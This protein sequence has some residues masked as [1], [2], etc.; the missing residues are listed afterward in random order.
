MGKHGWHQTNC[1]CKPWHNLCSLQDAWPLQTGSQRASSQVSHLMASFSMAFR[2]ACLLASCFTTD[3]QSAVARQRAK[4]GPWLP[5][6]SRFSG[7]CSLSSNLEIYR[8]GGSAHQWESGSSLLSVPAL[9]PNVIFKLSSIPVSIYILKH[10]IA[11]LFL[12]QGWQ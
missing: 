4:V 2:K 5:V 12:M 10:Y 7:A 11:F 1:H 6:K 3:Y 8:Y 9:E